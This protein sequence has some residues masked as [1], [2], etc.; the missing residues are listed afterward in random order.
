MHIKTQEWLVDAPGSVF[1]GV[2]RDEL[3]EVLGR[4]KRQRFPSGTVI[5]AEGERLRVMYVTET[6]SADVLFTDRYGRQQ[7]VGRIEPGTTFGEMSLFTGDPAAATVRATEDLEAL[8][9]GHEDFERLA[10]RFPVI[11][12]NLAE[13]LSERLADTNRLAAERA[14]G[15]VILLQDWSAPPL[16]G[17][18]LACSIA[19]HTRTR[20]LL[21]VLGEQFPE[22]LE[23]LAGAAGESVLDPGGRRT[24][25]G[26]DVALVTPDGPFETERLV[27]TADEL[28]ARYDYVLLMVKGRVP[29]TWRRLNLSGTV[30]PTDDGPGSGEITVRAWVGP[31]RRA[32]RPL[33]GLLDVPALQASDESALLAGLLPTRSPAGRALGWLARDLTGLKLGL[34]LGAGSVR[35]YAHL[36]VLR[37]LERLGITPDYLAGTSIGAAVGVLP[38]LGVSATE[39]LAILDRAAGGAFRPTF[40]L[41]ALLSGRGVIRFAQSVTGDMRMEDLDIPFATVAAD[42]ISRR[43]IVLRSG[44]LWRA[45]VAS[46][47]IPGI[48]PA[49]RMGPWVLVDGAVIDPVPIS[50][51]EDMGADVVI[52]VSLGGH[53]SEPVDAAE[54]LAVLGRP[55]RVFG[56]LM[57]SIEIMQSRVFDDATR[58]TSIMLRPELPALIHG[59]LR[60]FAAGRRFVDEGERA[61]EE[62]LPRMAAVLPWLRREGV[63][64]PAERS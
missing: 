9:I 38:A 31:H 59:R 27:A 60:N 30:K 20:T 39:G 1:E 7:L 15:R 32:P 2:P 17:Y 63:I 58:V 44:V 19:W 36:G 11:Y 48:Y 21:V 37:V 33:A 8:V 18:A 57:P 34:A 50:V 23:R 47:A 35:G 12:R 61:A 55:P 6:G 64:V 3:E 25:P 22:E 14:P 4:A 26:V 53:P 52:G 54:S 41:Y 40:P 43:K 45:L 42:L 49:Q 56:V 62:A 51:C 10:S 28:A 16:L 24:E 13:I 29:G 5:L 46:M